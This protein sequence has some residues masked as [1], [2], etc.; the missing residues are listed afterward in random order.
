MSKEK[1]CGIY[2]IENLV[3]GKKY[4]GQSVNF[5]GRQRQHLSH[6][7]RNIHKNEY[8]QNAWNKYGE[9]N[10]KFS[11]IEI[12]DIDSLD[13]L[14]RFYID[15]YNSMDVK[16][17]YNRESGGNLKKK[18]SEETKNK[19][20]KNHADVSKENNPFYNKKH[21]KE[22][23]QKYL[24]NPNYIN[25]KH[26]GVDSHTCTITEEVARKIKEHFL[27]GHELYRGEVAD[28]ARKYNTNIS[29][30]SHIKNGHAWKWL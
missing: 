9:S 11:I 30:V 3:N 19:I 5:V 16:Y 10:F 25:R 13:E 26:R 15:K 4:I 17:G 8:L 21:S 22:S 14:E 7:R 18:A 24:E 29:V 2:C 12:C 1:I 6:L 28:I 27:D 20:S 23:I